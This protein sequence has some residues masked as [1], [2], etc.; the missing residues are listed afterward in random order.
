MKCGKKAQGVAGSA[1][2]VAAG[3]VM[4]LS[5]VFVIVLRSLQVSG[6]VGQLTGVVLGSQ[7]LVYMRMH[8][9]TL[10]KK[11]IVMVHALMLTS[12]VAA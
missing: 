1:V 11:L 6:E 4:L 10:L 8:V 3:N 2:T 9:I 12:K 5:E 7:P